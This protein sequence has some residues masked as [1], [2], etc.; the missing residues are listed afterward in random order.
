MWTKEKVFLDAACGLAEYFLDRLASTGSEVLPWDFDAPVDPENP[1]LD[2]SVGVI[3]ANGMLL[4]SEALSEYFRD[5][6]IRVVKD[7][8]KY[9]LA[10]E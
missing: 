4:I 5:A 9:V 3:T 7:L 2:S 10:E 1:A 6:A 8:L